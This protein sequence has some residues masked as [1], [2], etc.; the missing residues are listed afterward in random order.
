MKG[1]S[2]GTGLAFVGAGDEGVNGCVGAGVEVDGMLVAAGAVV[3]S[4]VGARVDGI[5]DDWLGTSVG[6]GVVVVGA[7]EVGSTGCAVAVGICP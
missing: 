4:A 3:S 7:G 5:W 1:A 6:F 2:V